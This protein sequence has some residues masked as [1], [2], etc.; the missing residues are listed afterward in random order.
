MVSG[1]DRRCGEVVAVECP[2]FEM[3]KGAL[4]LLRTYSTRCGDGV[5]GTVR[6]KP[7]SV[8]HPE[9]DWR[10]DETIFGVVMRT[11]NVVFGRQSKSWMT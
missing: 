1:E 2:G 7:A 4:T 11:E 9:I 6:P 8:A 10:M 5:Q 3:R